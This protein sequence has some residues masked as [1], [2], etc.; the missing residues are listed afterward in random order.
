MDAERWEHGSE[1][2]WPITSDDS[3]GT[4]ASAPWQRDGS[5]L[6]GCG[7]DALRLL[8]DHGRRV[9][10]WSRLWVPSYMCQHVVE[11]LVE[12][13]IE[14]VLYQD[15][16]HWTRPD[17]ATLEPR[18]SDAVLVVNYFGLRDR[19]ALEGLALQGAALVVDHTHDPL[20]EWALGGDADYALA[21]LRKTLPIPEGGV[22]WSPAGHPLPETP[23]LTMQRSAALEAK[24]ESMALKGRYLSGE[25]VEK[26]VYRTLASEGE[27]AMAQGPISGLSPETLLTLEALP[28]GRWRT[29]RARNFATLVESVGEARGLS[30]LA[31]EGQGCPFS[32]FL[33]FDEPEVRNRVRQI[34]IENA[35]YPAILWPLEHS[36]LSGVPREHRTL[37]DRSLSVH[38]DMR[39]GD[40]DMRRVAALI[41]EGLT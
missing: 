14:C 20:S 5:V 37:A 26:S 32:A 27:T 10:H 2:H 22:L 33:I 12:T 17:L 13:G 38:C 7:R 3:P 29:L 36:V 19:G 28:V 31:P 15:A 23:E 24:R 35:C 8:I 34:L 21:S 11:T 16:P 25:P 41:L 39:Y 40:E 6:L 30:I 4:L 18:S 9:H 1:F